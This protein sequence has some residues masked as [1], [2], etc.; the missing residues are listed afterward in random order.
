MSEDVTRRIEHAREMGRIVQRLDDGDRRMAEIQSTVDSIR[1]AQ[2]EQTV[3]LS[4]L[5]KQLEEIVADRREK[6]RASI[7]ARILTGGGVV[8]SGTAL[9]AIL[10]GGNADAKKGKENDRDDSHATGRRP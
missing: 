8:A 4:G 5:S 2:T 10:T 9:W 3:V 7:W 1:S 6:R